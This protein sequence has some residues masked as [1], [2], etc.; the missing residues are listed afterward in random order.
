VC[1]LFALVVL[2]FFQV[3]GFIGNVETKRAEAGS[4]ARLRAMDQQM[5]A[6]RGQFNGLL[7]ESIEN[8]LRLLQKSVDSGKA[9]ADDLR[10]FAELQRDLALLE[11]YAGRGTPVPA[12]ESFEHMRYQP[13]VTAPPPRVV[14]NDQ[15]LDEVR[16]LKL[17]FVVSATGI[18]LVA[19][20]LAVLYALRQR[21]GLRT[22]EAPLHAVPGLE[23]P[24]P[25]DD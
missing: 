23:P 5:Q 10:V 3:Q 8:R 19:L 24:D 14:R 22:L 17:L 2:L 16:Q 13:L 25:R 1:I 11:S 18:A 9:S 4:D 7:A 15:L 12:A 21:R 6:L 20:V